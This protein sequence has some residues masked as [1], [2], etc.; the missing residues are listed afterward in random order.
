MQQIT[1]PSC[2]R[3]ITAV[4]VAGGMVKAKNNKNENFR[5]KKKK[6]ELKSFSQHNTEKNI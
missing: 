5:S 1:F 2:Q 4:K 3:A 6:I